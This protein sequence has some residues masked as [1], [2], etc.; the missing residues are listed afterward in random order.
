MSEAMTGGLFDEHTG[1]IAE[2]L[3]GENKD[4]EAFGET[5]FK[6]CK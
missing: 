4:R 1:L 2:R 5:P 3:S 6:Q